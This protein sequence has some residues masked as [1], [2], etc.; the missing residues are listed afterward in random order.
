MRDCLSLHGV[1]F[2]LMSVGYIRRV[3]KSPLMCVAFRQAVPRELSEIP[4]PPDFLQSL[5]LLKDHSLSG[6]AVKVNSLRG[7]AV[8]DVRVLL[9]TFRLLPRRLFPALRVFEKI[10]E[11]HQVKKV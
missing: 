11:G 7:M 2:G 1:L 9:S 3:L 8:R 10:K 5:Q 4:V 6:Q